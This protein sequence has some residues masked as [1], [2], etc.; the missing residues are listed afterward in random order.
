MNSKTKISPRSVYGL[1]LIST[2]FLCGNACYVVEKPKDGSRQ[3]AAGPPLR[4]YVHCE[5][6]DW[7]KGTFKRSQDAEKISREHNIK[8]HDYLKVAY[9]DTQNCSK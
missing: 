2:L 1:V 6:C 5:T 3:R 8:M 9:Y 7:C 4:Y